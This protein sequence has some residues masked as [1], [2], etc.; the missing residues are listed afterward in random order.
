[1]ILT[2]FLSL[3]VDGVAKFNSQTFSNRANMG[4]TVF[5][6]TFIMGIGSEKR[7]KLL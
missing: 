5:L 6:K 1:M 7:K 3:P 2:I 4:K